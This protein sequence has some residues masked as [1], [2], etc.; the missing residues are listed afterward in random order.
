M[1]CVLVCQDTLALIALSSVIQSSTVPVMGCVRLTGL[2]LVIP[3]TME[4][5]VIYCVLMGSTMALVTVIRV[6]MELRVKPSVLACKLA[7]VTETALEMELAIVR[8]TSMVPGVILF[9]IPH[10]LAMAEDLVTNKVG[11]FSAC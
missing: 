2:A 9:A 1:V 5:N 8:I 7:L 4:H 3:V 10:K 6:I 11:I